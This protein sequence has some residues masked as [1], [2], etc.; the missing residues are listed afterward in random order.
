MSLAVIDWPASWPPW[1]M[2]END[3]FR[4]LRVGRGAK[5]AHLEARANSQGM[6]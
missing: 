4:A 6:T 3:L 1:G 2:Q 5:H